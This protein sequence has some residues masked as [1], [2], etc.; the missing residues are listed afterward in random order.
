MTASRTNL[1]N[2][3][4]NPTSTGSAG[5]ARAAQRGVWRAWC[6]LMAR[7]LVWLAH[8]A[9]FVA[10]IVDEAVTA[11]L[12]IPA[13]LPRLQRWASRA[14]TEWRVYRAVRAGD[15]IEAD[16]IERVWR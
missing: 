13:V 2:P 5:A 8:L 15:V 3:R 11:R 7:G 16:V 12:G 4:P 6:G 9:L 14:R 10:Q 1:P